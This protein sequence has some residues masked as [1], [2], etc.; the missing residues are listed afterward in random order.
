VA[1]SNCARSTIGGQS[2]EA[3]TPVTTPSGDSNTLYVYTWADYVSEDLSQLFKEK[4]GIDVIVDA[5][6]SNETMLAKLQ[7]G[8]GSQYS[9]IYPSDYMVRQMTDLQLLTA[10]DASR[11]KGLDTLL[12]KWKSPVYDS[13]NAHSIPFTIGT[14]GL[15]YNSDVLDGKPEGLEF[16]WQNKEALAGKMTLLDDVRETMGAVLKM[17]GYSY[18]TTD[19]AE[20]EMAYQQLLELKSAIA[21][22]KTY[23]WEDQ[24]ISGDLAICMS[25]STLGNLLPLD[26]PNLVYVIPQNGTSVWTDTMAIPAS[27]PNIEAAYTWINFMMEPEHARLAV[28]KLKIATPIVP[29]IELLPSDVK[30]NTKLFPTSEMLAKCEGIT[31]VGDAIDLYDKYWTELRSA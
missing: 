16:L 15:L 8:G 17:L 31:P 6:D 22:F 11:I 4:T 19:P 21:S 18:N 28:E 9:I 1:F 12:D 23:G 10:L 7:A 24:L 29:A 3:E 25:Y 2:A 26:H 30:N 5:Y 13:D 20:V 14:T 27:A